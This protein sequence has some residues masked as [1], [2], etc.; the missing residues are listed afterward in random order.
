MLNKTIKDVPESI[1]LAIW[2]FALF[3]ALFSLC[4]AHFWCSVAPFSRREYVCGCKRV[5]S[6]TRDGLPSGLAHTW[7]GWRTH[8]PLL[9]KVSVECDAAADVALIERLLVAVYAA[10]ERAEPRVSTVVVVGGARVTG[11]DPLVHADVLNTLCR[12]TSQPHS[13]PPLLCLRL[14]FFLPAPIH[15]SVSPV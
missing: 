9:P 10:T 3:F 13:T 6:C 1:Y 8:S 14:T 11:V 2:S 7:S 4:H 12:V 15:S 5:C